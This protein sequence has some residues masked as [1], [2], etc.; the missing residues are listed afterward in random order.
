MK[1][2][3]VWQRRNIPSKNETI[4]SL[5]NNYRQQ[6]G[7]NNHGYVGLIEPFDKYGRHLGTVWCEDN[8]YATMAD[9]HLHL[10]DIPLSM[11]PKTQ[12]GEDPYLV[13]CANN[14]PEPHPSHKFNAS[15]HHTET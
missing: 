5:F 7:L 9:A 2:G 14:L 11:Y 13:P 12:S 1:L 8:G 3:L 6:H 4:T 15:F 10:S